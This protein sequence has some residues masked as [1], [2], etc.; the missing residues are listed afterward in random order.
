MMQYNET[1]KKFSPQLVVKHI[2]LLH[3][4]PVLNKRTILYQIQLPCVC[5]FPVFL[6]LSFSIFQP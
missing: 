5:Y 1:L 3:L 2:C 6:E 4:Y